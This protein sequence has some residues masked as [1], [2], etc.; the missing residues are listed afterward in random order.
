ML[1]PIKSLYY[2]YF[3]WQRRY[4]HRDMAIWSALSFMIVCISMYVVPLVKLFFYLFFY[5]APIW[6]KFF[7]H[8]VFILAILI[9]MY[10]IVL[11]K[12]YLEIIKD[13]RYK[14]KL[15]SIFAVFFIIFSFITIYAGLGFMYL[16]D[17]N[18]WSIKI[19]LTSYFQ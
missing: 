4:G 11:H 17:H 6:S 12:K 5:K 18:I 14:T 1:N 3:W 15:Q 2:Q 19:P 13:R 7:Q 16:C 10:N 8:T 9:L